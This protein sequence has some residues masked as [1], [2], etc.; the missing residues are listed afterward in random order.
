VPLDLYLNSPTTP[1]S[2]NALLGPFWQ[3]DEALHQGADAMLS[4]AQD[5]DQAL[6]DAATEANKIIEDYNQK[7]KD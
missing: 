3:V 1:A 2:L 6:E 5:P 7:V 4:G